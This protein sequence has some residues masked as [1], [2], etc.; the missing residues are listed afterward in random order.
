VLAAGVMGISRRKF[1]LTFGGAK[2]IRYTLLAYFSSR[3]GHQIIHWTRV[4]YAFVLYTLL[5]LLLIGIFMFGARA[6]YRRHK[7]KAVPAEGERAP[8][9]A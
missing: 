4:N 5:G 8:K 9:T 1:L 2:A 6:F 7:G 3:Y